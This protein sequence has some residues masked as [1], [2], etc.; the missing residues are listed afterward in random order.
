MPVAG[1]P[2]F[3]PAP[4][5]APL[6]T[7]TLASHVPFWLSNSAQEAALYLVEKT[8]GSGCQTKATAAKCAPAWQPKRHNPRIAQE[9]MTKPGPQ[10]H[11]Q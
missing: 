7:L 1:Q 5:S 9:K 4:Q 3:Q 10:T 11:L 2:L 8:D 6:Y